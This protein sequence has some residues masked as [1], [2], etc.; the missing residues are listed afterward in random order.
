MTVESG[1]PLRAAVIG[2]GVIAHDHL[3]FL[4]RTSNGRLVGLCDKSAALAQAACD[5]YAA[6]PVY[7]DASAMLANEKPDIVHVLT[8]PQTHDAI[9]RQALAAGAHVICEKPMTGTAAETAGLL[10]AAA[11]AGRVLVESRNLLFNDPVLSLLETIRAG[12]IG[13]VRE[14]DVLLQLDFLAGPF[15]DT[16]LAGP[17]VDLPGGAVHDFL[18]H[19]VYLFQELTDTKEVKAVHGRLEN[20]SGNPRAGFDFLD[21]LVD[22]GEARGRLRVATD[23]EPSAF[24]VIVR[25]SRASV[26]TDLYN[27][28]FR[29][30]GP[31]DIGKR[32]PL[33]QMRAGF[34]L[35]GAGLAN[36]RNKI[37]QHGTIHGMGRMLEAVY[38]AIR[39]GEAPPI[40]P[41]DILATARMTDGIVALGAAR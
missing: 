10:E 30:E 5:H 33:G 12:R 8:P 18:P 32:A 19:L 28:F 38:S 14:C 13:T 4:A 21:V 16:N 25:G 26:E 9:V 22:A 2:C 35:V 41:D 17:G 34:G 1:A 6:A 23:V 39:R 31:P 15:G 7:T 29:Y 24:R 40:T 27:P 3:A 20:L 36:L 11:A 37:G